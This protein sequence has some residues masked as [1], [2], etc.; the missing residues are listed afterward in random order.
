MYA[1]TSDGA[2]INWPL[3]DSFAV[4]AGP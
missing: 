1:Q 4:T 2:A 3:F